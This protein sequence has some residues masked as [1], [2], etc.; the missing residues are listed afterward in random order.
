MYEVCQRFA[1]EAPVPTTARLLSLPLEVGLQYIA[2]AFVELQDARH[3]A[4]YDLS[5]SFD[6][7]AVLRT[8]EMAGQAFRE[9]ALVKDRPNASVF[10]AALLLQRQWR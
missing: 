8:V 1:K 3:A 9:W 10:L 2:R 7:F 5:T 6:R 4:D